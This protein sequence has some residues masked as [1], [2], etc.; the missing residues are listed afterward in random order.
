MTASLSMKEMMNSIME[1]MVIGRHE[2]TLRHFPYLISELIRKTI[3][4]M[5]SKSV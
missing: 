1:F 4:K 3:L 5:N 2:D